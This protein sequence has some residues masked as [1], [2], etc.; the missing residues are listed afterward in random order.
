[1]A[2]A[3]SLSAT[4]SLI[5]QTKALVTGWSRRRA[6]G[7]EEGLARLHFI[8]LSPLGRC[9]G[10]RDRGLVRTAEQPEHGFFFHKYRH[11]VLFDGD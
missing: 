8:H 4:A 11:L 10:S 3:A 2:V 9:V 5:E 6:G 7:E 1:M